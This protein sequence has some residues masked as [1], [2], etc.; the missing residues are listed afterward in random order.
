MIQQAHLLTCQKPGREDLKYIQN[1]LHTEL[2]LS[3]CGPDATIW[4]SV[5]RRQDYSHDLISLHP[6]IDKDPFSSWAIDKTITYLFR[7][8]CARFM[9]ESPVHGVIGYEDMEVIR[10]TYWLTSI[11]ASLLLVSSIV[12]LYMV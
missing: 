6:K 7:C 11:A 4:G 5:L 12:V 2:G 10:V 8:G 3:L 1:F 9:K